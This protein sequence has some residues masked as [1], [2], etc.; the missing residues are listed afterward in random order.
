MANELKT[1]LATSA[2]DRKLVSTRA[3][4]LFLAAKEYTTAHKLTGKTL[5]ISNAT[6]PRKPGPPKPRKPKGKKAPMAADTASAG[7]N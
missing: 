1:S 4:D 7:G 5:K 3:T 6:P 2:P